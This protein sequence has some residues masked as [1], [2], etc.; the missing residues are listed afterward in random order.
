[1]QSTEGGVVQGASPNGFGPL[2]IKLAHGDGGDLPPRP[3]SNGAEASASRAS[4]EKGSQPRPLVPLQADPK[5]TIGPESADAGHSHNNELRVGRNELRLSGEGAAVSAKR[6]ISAIRAEAMQSSP[7]AKRTRGESNQNASSGEAAADRE[8]AE[9][10]T[11]WSNRS[12]ASTSKTQQPHSRADALP[13]HGE[14]GT[15]NS[16]SAATVS[17]TE[18]EDVGIPKCNLTFSSRVNLEPVPDL[19]PLP[20]LSPREV[21]ELELALQIGDKLNHGDENTWRED[22]SG[23][24]QLIDKDLVMNRDKIAQDASIKPST[25]PFLDWVAKTSSGPDDVRGARLLFSYVYHMTGT[26]PMAKKIMTHVL[27]REASSIDNRIDMIHQ[28]LQRISYDPTVLN[29]DG[30]TTEKAESPEGASGGAFLIGRRIFWQRYEAVIIAFVRDEEIGDLW[31]AIWLEDHDT[32]DVEADEL[33]DAIK[34]WE[35]RAARKDASRRAGKSTSKRFAAS[36]NFTVDG[37]EHGIVLATSMHPNAR[38]GLFWPARVMHVSEVEEMSSST[39]KRSSSKNSVHIIFLSPYWNG[40]SAYPPRK[41]M[42]NNFDPMDV[43]AANPFCAGPLF[44]VEMLEVSKESIK[45]YPHQNVHADAIPIE[46]LRSE[47]RFLGLPKAAFGRYLDSHRL[48]MALKIFAKTDIVG[49]KSGNDADLAG[50]FASLTDTHILSVKSPRFPLAVL[51]LPFDYILSKLPHP[52]EKARIDEDG[53]ELTEPIIKVHLILKA[54]VPPFCWG[55][56]ASAKNNSTETNDSTESSALLCSPGKQRSA[57]QQISSPVPALAASPRTKKHQNDSFDGSVES[58]W[59]LEHVCSEYLLDM[60]N[61]APLP[62]PL[63]FLGTQLADLLGSLQ[64]DVNSLSK[65]SESFPAFRKRVMSKWLGKCLLVKAHGED[66][67]SWSRSGDSTCM[68]EWRKTCERVYKRAA[69]GLSSNGFGDGVTAIITDSRCNQHITSSGSFERAVRLPAAIR[70][71]KKAGAGSSKNMPLIYTVDDHYIELAEKFVLPK[72]HKASYLKRL[73]NKI[74]NMP[75]D[76]K[77]VPLTDDSDGEGGQDTMGSRGS[78][79]AAVVGVAAALKSVDMVV[80][81]HCVNAFCAIRPPGHHAGKELRPM[82]AVS[83]GFCL[84]NAAASAALYAT[85]AKSDGGLGL[86]R[87]CVIDFDVH[88]GNGTQDILCSTHDPRFLYVS[89]HA[90]GAPINGYDQGST[91]YGL[92]RYSLGASKNEGIFPGR[93]GD[94]SPHEGVLNIPLGIKVTATAIGQA[95]VTQVAPAVEAFSPELIV[96]SAGF[97][98][99]QN[100]PMGMGSLTAEDFG[101]VTE[102]ACQMAYKTCSGRVISVLEGGYG[103]P[104]CVPQKDLFLPRRLKKSGAAHGTLQ[105]PTLLDLG[106]DLPSGMEDE[107]PV[108]LRQQLDRCH[109][110]GFMACVEN[111]VGSL[112]KLSSRAPRK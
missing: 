18:G 31:K 24:L 12:L 51:G 71:A 33:Q 88:H 39:S 83:N 20:R 41:K 30:W 19:P 60:I 59:H 70:G 108:A 86:K 29:Q 34:K 8:V 2:D 4:E 69:I 28:A 102:V 66:A 50:A 63:S 27:Y 43:N 40:E 57:A 17:P 36:S 1:M 81:G 26:P 61:N 96:L 91:D 93:C 49:A 97:D 10:N 44:E 58:A 35:R 3:N 67:L 5:D 62:S 68:Q 105:Q 95:L 13:H 73:K 46:K 72:A 38:R 15:I 87:V 78:F 23:N 84:L 74:A 85:L 98:A 75:A 79:T 112:A 100:D 99:H 32:F 104:C 76:A 101:T 14:G 65:E 53:D 111:H 92:T 109:L 103:V 107:V 106:G 21:A 54:M 64:K 80:K 94:T 48:A 77:G 7:P 22:W 25:L 37:I 9:A 45:K 89:L 11:H 47:F 55:T 56:A 6:D 90:G 42:L 16:V 82:K 110:E 52:S